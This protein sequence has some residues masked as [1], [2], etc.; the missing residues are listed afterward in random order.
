[1]D[2]TLIKGCA[3][4]LMGRN[5]VHLMRF[6][7]RAKG[8]STLGMTMANSYGHRNGHRFV[9]HMVS[10]EGRVAKTL[11][12]RAFRVLR[13]IDD[14]SANLRTFAMHVF[15]HGTSPHNSPP[16]NLSNIPAIPTA[17]PQSTLSPPQPALPRRRLLIAATRMT[18]LVLG[19]PAL[20]ATHFQPGAAAA[21]TGDALLRS[22][23]QKF[24]AQDVEGSLDDFD[25]AYNA[26]PHLRPYMWQRGLSLYY[27]GS[28]CKRGAAVCFHNIRHTTNTTTGRYEEAAAQFRLD[29]AVNPNDTEE[30]IW[31]FLAEAKS[32]GVTTARARFMAVGRDPRPVMRAAYDAFK[33]GTGTTPIM[34]AAGGQTDSSDAFYVLLVR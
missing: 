23:L 16:Q 13:I 26:Y 2:S 32:I 30:C 22:G 3:K 10:A 28:A 6:V 9:H 21:L 27:A 34:E 15:A 25:A 11:Y 1:M 33:D 17:S 18:P 5:V 24:R 14:R 4:C 31:A 20:L 7:L 29:V 19:T 12:F 8:C